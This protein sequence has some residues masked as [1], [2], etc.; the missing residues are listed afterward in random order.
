MSEIEELVDEFFKG[1]ETQ[2]Q[3]NE[4]WRQFLEWFYEISDDE[5]WA[6]F[7]KRLD[8]AIAKRSAH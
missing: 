7:K 1:A 5:Q 8:E 4:L 3:R 6:R 2:E